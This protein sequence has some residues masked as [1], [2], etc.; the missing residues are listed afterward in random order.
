MFLYSSYLLKFRRQNPA[1]VAPHAARDR[2]HTF[3]RDPVRIIPQLVVAP[4]AET[5]SGA[6]HQVSALDPQFACQSLEFCRGPCTCTCMVT[7]M[8]ARSEVVTHCGAL[9]S[10][11]APLA[12]VYVYVRVQYSQC[13]STIRCRSAK[14]QACG[15][16]LRL[17]FSVKY[18]TL[19]STVAVI[20]TYNKHCHRCHHV[21]IGDVPQSVLFRENTRATITSETMPS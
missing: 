11:S 9:K 21:S 6:V 4:S 19:S 16:K 17:S 2:H 5:R 20:R 1:R 13:G 10:A 15:E 7:D 18:V 14:F 12:R 8:Y 3:G